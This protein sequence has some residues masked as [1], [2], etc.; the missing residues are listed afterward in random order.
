MD[1]DQERILSAESLHDMNTG[2]PSKILDLTPAAIGAKTLPETKADL[3]TAQEKITTVLN[4][5]IDE[6]VVTVVELGNLADIAETIT[7]SINFME[8]LETTIAKIAHLH[9]DV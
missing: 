1:K 7:S 4:K 6:D 3:Y 2:D 8:H 9:V 5:M